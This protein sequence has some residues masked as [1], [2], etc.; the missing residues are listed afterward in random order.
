MTNTVLQ[1]LTLLFQHLHPLAI[2][3]Q[4][5]L[6]LEFRIRAVGCRGTRIWRL[7][8]ARR[9]KVLGTC[10]GAGNHNL[11]GPGINR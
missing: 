8:H 5:Q 11:S 4:D 3:R 10:R 2:P 7:V 1:S 9:S 6:T